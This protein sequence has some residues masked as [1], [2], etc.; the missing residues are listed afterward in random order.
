MVKWIVLTASL[1]ALLGCSKFQ[2]YKV[3][4]DDPTRKERT[5]AE[6]Y[7][8]NAPGRVMNTH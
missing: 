6:P 8:H 3:S 2:D 7:S 5:H 4:V 1:L